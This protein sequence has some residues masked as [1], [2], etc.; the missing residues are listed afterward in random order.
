MI[1]VNLRICLNADQTLL[2][3]W[4]KVSKVIN[5]FYIYIIANMPN[6]FQILKDIFRT[7]NTNNATFVATVNDMNLWRQ[8]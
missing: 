1:A 5:N 4:N 2:P 7:R 6:T 3:A 8:A